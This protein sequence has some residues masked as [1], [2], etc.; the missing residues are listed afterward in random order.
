LVVWGCAEMNLEC[1]MPSTLGMGTF[2]SRAYWDDRH[3][4]RY[5]PESVGFIGLGVPYNVWMYRVR[6]HVVER[7][8]RQARI[9]LSQSDVLDVGSG[10]GF[11]IDLW[12]RL[13]AKSVTGSD[14][15][16]Y[17][18]ASLRER[19]P[20]HRVVELDIAS[21]DLPRELGPFDLVSAFDILYHIVDD[22]RYAQA[23]RN[24]AALVRPGGYFVFSENFM[25][26]ERHVG[27]HQVSR[28]CSEITELLVDNG[29][30]IV[31]RAPVFWI[32]NRPIKSQSWMLSATW[33]AIERVTSKHDRP[34]LGKW[35]G[36]AL[37]PLEI[38]TLRW[39]ST[40]PTTEMMICRRCP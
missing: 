9:D 14:F 17:A 1:E 20:D 16:P 18:V 2:D 26:S 4:K 7:E 38:S 30:E 12:S 25:S 21:C 37:Y 13:R 28:S 23:V 24:V 15:A 27:I 33:S 29:L 35:L 11:Y 40:G 32:M 5:G 10:T 39:M 36:A 8:I 34:Y 6:R 22:G 19:F 3:A 31:R